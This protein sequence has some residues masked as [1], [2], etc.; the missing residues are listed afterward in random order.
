ME[1]RRGG[2][3]AVFSRGTDE[4]P[5]SRGTEEEGRS[6]GWLGGVPSRRL[7]VVVSR[8]GGS[9]KRTSGLAEELREEEK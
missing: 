3:L 6:G 1:R 7:V 5:L 2:R 4:E 9:R 8:N